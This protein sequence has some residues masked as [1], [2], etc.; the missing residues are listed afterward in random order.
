MYLENYTSEG[1]SMEN[2]I[3]ITNIQRFSLHDGPGIR[4]T[5]FCKG[6]SLRCPWCANPE[7]LEPHPEEYIKDGNP[8][9]YGR[10]ISCEELIEEAMK[11]ELFYRQQGRG[12][13]LDALPG[14]VT[15]SG[16]EP[17]LQAARLE[18]VWRGLRDR[19]V[20]LCVETCL[21]VP[22]DML[23]LALRYIDLFYVD[24]KVLDIERCKNIIHGDLK[25][26]LTNVDILFSGNRKVV[27]RIPVIGTYT[28]DEKNR[29]ETISMLKEYKPLKV[30]LIKE[31]NL[32]QSKY[33]SLGKEPLD[34][35][36]VT[37]AFMEQYK[38]DIE[39]VTGI[40]AEIC[41]I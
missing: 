39:E 19:D 31:H 23:V 2:R 13:G 16:G 6:C 5:V 11:D 14:G 30:E 8:G 7:N 29:E 25:Q 40:P 35:H 24:I 22:S 37:D 17:L 36:T 12:A 33:F 26:Y 27:F 9:K 28:D 38:R 20:H 10:Y 4:T 34:L 3:L 18:P 41:R 1:K 21:F 15:F 32:G